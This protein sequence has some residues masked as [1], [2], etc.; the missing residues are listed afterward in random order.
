MNN[1]WLIASYFS[2]QALKMIKAFTLLTPEGLH[3]AAIGA[4]LFAWTLDDQ[5]C[6]TFCAVRLH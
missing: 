2:D 4:E 5:W 6:A 3:F 1:F